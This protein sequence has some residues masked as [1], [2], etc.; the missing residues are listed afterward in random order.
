[1]QIGE[2]CSKEVGLSEAEL[3]KVKAKDF[4]EP[5]ENIKC[6]ANC[7][8]EKVGTLKDGVIQPEVVLTKLGAIIGEE[9]TRAALD[10]CSSIKGVNNCDTA[11]KLHECFDEFK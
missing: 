7:F 4:S 10:K 6:F 1:K 2:T 9:K 3:A 11:V 8:F 5:S